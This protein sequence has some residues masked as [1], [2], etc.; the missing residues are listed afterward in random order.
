V[1]HGPVVVR[2][3]V[4]PVPGLPAQADGF[5]IAHISDLHLY[6]WHRALQ[7]AQT[8]LLGLQYDLL[9]VTGDLCD[10]PYRWEV[11]AALTQRFFGPI[12]PRLGTFAVLGNHDSVQLADQ[13]DLPVTFLR[14]GHVTRPIKG[15]RLVLAGVEQ[16][17]DGESDLTAT[18]GAIP[19]HLPTILLAHFPSTAF[20]LNQRAVPLVLSGHTHGGQ[21]RLPVVGCVWTA[22]RLPC[23]MA[24]GLHVVNGRSLHVSAGLGVPRKFPLRFMCPPEITILTLAAAGQPCTPKFTVPRPRAADRTQLAEPI[25]A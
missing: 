15:G 13:S 6:R 18:L 3:W 5:Q 7:H 2:R 20:E 25:P 1:I 11:A 17:G 4:V 23:R 9:V 14:N 19:A 12:R 24:R 10:Q 16:A 8:L 22:D 21:V